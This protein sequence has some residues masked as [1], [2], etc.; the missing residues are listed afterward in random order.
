MN[1]P[2][3]HEDP[4]PSA[5]RISGSRAELETLLIGDPN[6]PFPRSHTMRALRNSGPA[7]IAGIALGLMVVKPRWGARMMRL[8]PIARLLKRVPM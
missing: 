4:P 7:W 2:M 6:S 5:Q 8:V 3:N 1:P